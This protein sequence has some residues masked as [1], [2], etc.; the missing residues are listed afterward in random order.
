VQVGNGSLKLVV[1]GATH[2]APEANTYVLTQQLIDHFRANPQEVPPQVRLYLIPLLNPDGLALN[3][4]FNAA[5][6]DLNRNMNT[7]LDSC[8]ENDWRTRVF[9]AGGIVSDTGGPYADSEVESRLIRAFLLDASGAIFLHSNAGLVFPA[10][11]E[12]QPSIRMAEA[13]AGG[14]TYAYNRF[15]L[16][17]PINGGMHDWAASLGIAS[18]IP[19][20]VSGSEPEFEQ[21][22]A[23]VRAV[24]AQAETI[25]T[26]PAAQQVNGV[27]VPAEIWRYWRALGG[28]Q[29]FGPPLEAAQTTP[30]GMVQRFRNGT[31]ELNRNQRDTLSL[32]QPTLLGT[33]RLAQVGGWQGPAGT[34]PAADSSCVLFPET[35]HTLRQGFRAFWEQHGGL[36]VF[37]YP[38]SEET[39]SRSADGSPRAMQ[40]FERVVFS[41]DPGGNRVV[42]E[43]IGWQV[44]LHEGA[45]AAWVAQQIR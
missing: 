30:T 14:A 27:A 4:R 12:H 17:Y 2:G 42:V 25:L 16:R 36:A 1:V 5:G 24:L 26:P 45:R 29:I 7:D 20:L 22:L 41:Y 6:V 44:K 39:A 34:C 11:C 3:S 19:E 37:G 33:T 23:G 21:N 31:L 28:E 8:P 35:G 43:P 15:W 38:L 40:Y 18:V 32:V 9:G 10:L 13:Y